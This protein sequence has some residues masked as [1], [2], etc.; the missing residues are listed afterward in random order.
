MQKS[1]IHLYGRGGYAAKGLPVYIVYICDFLPPSEYDIC[2]MPTSGCGR[3]K[4]PSWAT[5]ENGLR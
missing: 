3:I 1:T 4:P 5:H 2:F